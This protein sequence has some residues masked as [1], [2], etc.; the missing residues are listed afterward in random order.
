M[1]SSSRVNKWGL[2]VSGK[3]LFD[4][5]AVNNETEWLLKHLFCSGLDKASSNAYFLCIWH[6]CLQAFER[7]SGEDFKPCKN[8][9]S[10]FLPSFILD[11][12]FHDLSKL[13]PECLPP[14]QALP[15][16]MATYKQHKAKYR[17]LTNAHNTVFSNIALL[18][19]ITSNLIL[20]S[21]KIWAHTK[22]SN[23]E[24]FLQ[25][26]TSIFWLVNSIID[27]TLN[28][29]SSMHDIYV[30]DISR[31]Y[32]TIPLNGSDN[33]FQAISFIV[34]IAFK[35]SIF[36]TSKHAHQHVGEVCS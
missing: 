25:V 29:P 9:L 27:T 10:W 12:V 34:T 22:V 21:V 5:P 23:Y 33:L 2:Q 14:Y 3:F 17:W 32:E 28:L 20:E 4:I 31:C 30:A 6:I 35:T 11:K 36:I 8:D 13:L 7:L 19:T 18:L 15:Y 1:K 24:N 26:D 16:L